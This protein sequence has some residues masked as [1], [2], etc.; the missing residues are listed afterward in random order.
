MDPLNLD[1]GTMAN[2]NNGKTLKD[3]MWRKY[4]K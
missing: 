1:V 2:R 4:H 3:D